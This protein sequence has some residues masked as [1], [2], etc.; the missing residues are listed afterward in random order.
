MLCQCLYGA[1]DCINILYLL[2]PHLAILVNVLIKRLIAV[3]MR[4]SPVLWYFLGI[5]SHVSAVSHMQ[6]IETVTTLV[7]QNIIYY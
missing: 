1:L 4:S 2:L 3:T 5:L 6:L 7:L